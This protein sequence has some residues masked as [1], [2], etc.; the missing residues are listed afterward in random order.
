MAH[1]SAI[2]RFVIDPSTRVECSRLQVSVR[3]KSTYIRVGQHIYDSL[4][5]SRDRDILRTCRPLH[6]RTGAKKNDLID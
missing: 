1:T 6:R 4:M 5:N 2:R 3:I